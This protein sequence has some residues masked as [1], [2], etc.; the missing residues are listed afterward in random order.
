MAA[1]R[2]VRE[3]KL[4]LS[5]TGLLAALLLLG[6]GGSASV[7]STGTPATRTPR[8]G[9]PTSES[10]RAATKAA[11]TPV[12]VPSKPADL[13]GYAA[14]ISAYLTDAGP[15]VLEGEC[16]KSLFQSWGMSSDAASL[17][18]IVGNTDADPDDEVAVLLADKG[19]D[20]SRWQIVVFDSPE[21]IFKAAYQSTPV[22]V[23]GGDMS[24][25]QS[26]LLA[27]GD[28]NND[29]KGEVAYSENV[30][31]AST[32]TVTV[33]VLTGTSSGYVSVAG[34]GLS[35]PTATVSMEHKEAEGRTEVWLHGGEIGSVGA[36]PQRTRTDVYAWDGTA[37]SLKQTTLDPTD[38]LYLK[39]TEADTLFAAGHYDEAL[40]VY[41]QALNDPNLQTWKQ[42]SEMVAPERPEL[43]AYTLFRVGLSSFGVSGPNPQGVAYI[44]QAVDKYAGYIHGD[45]AGAFLTSYLANNNVSQACAA[46]ESF[47]A[48]NLNLLEAFWDYGYSNPTFNADAVCP[49]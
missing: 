35:M 25:W 19:A 36:G 28:L 10:T 34:E 11:K 13:S 41:Q 31:G 21:G 4:L 32:C 42:Q 24:E 16:L 33:Y 2:R 3:M 18:C 40:S 23:P 37:C 14:A 27:A 17:S 15:S 46:V 7:K 48:D 9:T 5:A 38:I 22:E 6:C 12:A 8:S 1:R 29:G 44:Q 47:I 43:Y 30:C 20:T 26:K 49:F 39:V 45:M